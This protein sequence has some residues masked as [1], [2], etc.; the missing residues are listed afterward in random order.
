MDYSSLPQPLP[1]LIPADQIL[2]IMK[3]IVGQYQTVR[4]NI[5]ESVDG[6]IAIIAMLRYSSPDPASRQASEE[7]CAL[8][9]EDQA[10]FTAR[11]DFWPLLKA[12]KEACQEI[13]LHFEARKY[14][15]K[16]FLEFKQFGHGTLQP[17]QIH[18]YLERRNYIDGMRRKYNQRIREDAGGLWFS[19]DELAGV[20]KHDLDR[21][22]KDPEKHDMRFVRFSA[23]DSLVVYRN[24]SKSATRKRMYVGNVNNLSQNAKL[25]EK[26]VVERDLNARLVGYESHATYRLEKR[27]MKTPAQVESLLADLHD[28]LLA[29]GQH[30]MKLLMDLKRKESRESAKITE[31]D[32]NA[33]FPW[34][35]WYYARLAEQ[36]LH[37]DP[38][39]VAEYFPI[40]HVISVML[41]MF[42]GFLQLR[43]CP[44]SQ[45][46]LDGS[47][48]HDDVRAY[49]V[50]D[51]REASKG[52]F[53]G[54][55]Y[56][57]L[58]S[59]DNKYK[60]NQNVNLQ[61]GYMKNDGSR[62]YPATLLMCSFPPP[63]PSACTFLKHSQI[64]SLFHEL[65]HGIHDLLARTNYVAFHG[66]RS[67]P[68]F[69]EAFS[70]MLEKWCWM[71]PELKR[72]G[73]HYTSK[74]LHLKEKWL[75]EHP[76]ED[77]PPERIPDD[78]IERLIKGRQVTRPLWYLRQLVYAHFDMKVHHPRTHTELRNIDS[79]KIFN[80]LLEKLW[81]VR[82]PQPEDQG[83]PHADL[84]HLVSGYD[85]GYYSYLSAHVF[86][87]AF[88][89]STFLEDPR[90]VSAWDR[91][92]KGILEIGGSRD[93]LELLVEY[94]G[95]IPTADPLLRDILQ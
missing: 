68:D 14:L 27:L 84:G 13:S 40:Q 48:W 11:P 61:C 28:R 86:A 65:G 59:R 36:H 35:Y 44:I 91:Y 33:I 12:V 7:A 49:A 82:A 55:L 23:A 70:V 72:L 26:I 63:A 20:K 16:L 76:R 38:E 1:R 60:G 32:V 69:A 3:R 45:E 90:S 88:F 54:Y 22:G 21:F 15:D 29:R 9:N 47:A 73:L 42:S 79:T 66:H 89:E 51:G 19:L 25:F 52:R 18:E 56:M 67:P 34:D 57:D 31:Y 46:Q 80:D 95:H 92:R 64:I 10:A 58:L 85:A 2:P 8:V 78:T 4:E 17:V 62:V 39:Q 81:L 5:I 30:D 77:L 43:F 75:R 24:A 71:K 74:D 6:D 50:W 87:E 53:I 94:L 93:E 41:E 83:Y 37:V